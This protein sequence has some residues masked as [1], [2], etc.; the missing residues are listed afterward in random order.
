GSP[1]GA[2]HP[3]AAS[4]AAGPAAVDRAIARP[5]SAGA[6]STP[7][8]SAESIDAMAEPR[9]L[10]DVVSKHCESMVLP[11]AGAWPP[12][13]APAGAVR[14]PHDRDVAADCRGQGAWLS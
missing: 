10:D 12:P 5:G 4:A 9:R 3:A 6:R 14:R 8:G 1:G 13:R 11:P 7:G 2:G